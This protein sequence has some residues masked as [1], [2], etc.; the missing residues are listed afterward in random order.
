MMWCKP[1]GIEPSTAASRDLERMEVIVP[2]ICGS[3]EKVWRVHSSAIASLASAGSHASLP[4]AYQ[5]DDAIGC[6]VQSLSAPTLD[7][8]AIKL[9]GWW[10]RLPSTTFAT[11]EPAPGRKVSESRHS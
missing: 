2:R 10:S 7:T 3:F 8:P 6:P 4:K 9:S 11:V 1:S 5:F